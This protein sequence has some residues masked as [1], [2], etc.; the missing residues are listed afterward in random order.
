MPGPTHD[1]SAHRPL[2]LAL[3][4]NALSLFR[5]ALGLAFPWVPPSWRAA[6]VLVALLT[7]LLDGTSG[8]L[9]HVCSSTGRVLDPVADKVFILSVLVTLL[10]EGM[11]GIGEVLLLGLRDLAVLAGVVGGLLLADWEAFRHQSPTFLGKA[12]TAAQ[13]SFLLVLLL[14][15]R[16][17]GLAFPVAVAL[18][19]LAGLQYLALFLTRCR[20][21]RGEAVVRQ[22]P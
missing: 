17:K 20:S 15:P 12:A 21:R 11:L 1:P 3:V 6:V 13:F 4:P 9:L 18:S 19:G 14:A 2:L 10:A 7:D 5:L 22:E 16:G 8:R